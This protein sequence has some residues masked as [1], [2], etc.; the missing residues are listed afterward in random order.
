MLGK[1]LYDEDEVPFE[2][3]LKNPPF[4]FQ[5]ALEQIRRYYG[6][7]NDLKILDVGSR[8]GFFLHLLKEQGYSDISFVEPSPIGNPEFP[9]F[10]SIYDLKDQYDVITSFQTIEHVKE[11]PRDFLEH[12]GKHLVR[13]GLMIFTTPY[14]TKLDD[15][16]HNWHFDY[17]DIYDLCSVVSPKFEI[18][19]IHK[20]ERFHPQYNC[21]GAVIF[22]D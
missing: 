14:E 11:N 8:D 3:K 7:I 18:F 19:F 1:I 6:D 2:V 13:G 9:H 15:T 10:H 16:D 20:Y 21:F 5:F 12:L 4:R 22:K 17:Y